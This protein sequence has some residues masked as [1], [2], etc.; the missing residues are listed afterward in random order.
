MPWKA[1]PPCPVLRLSMLQTRRLPLPL[2]CLPPRPAERTTSRSTAR[3]NRSPS[4]RQAARKRQPL[5][6]TSV[7]ARGPCP[8]KTPAPASAPVPVPAPTPSPTPDS[9]PEALPV[10][11]K[12]E[13]RSLSRT[14]TAPPNLQLQP[15]AQARKLIKRN[16]SAPK[17]RIASR[18]TKTARSM[19]LVG[20]PPPLP[21]SDPSSP[22]PLPRAMSVHIPSRTASPV[23]TGQGA[24]RSKK[25]RLNSLWSGL[26]R[27]RVSS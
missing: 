21:T 15:Q 11:K 26:F 25:P 27:L 8:D 18:H 4:K 6:P 16:P 14:S 9:A 23:A 13:P 7:P 10:A 3:P 24:D 22:P 2:P 17:P 20:A 12:T 19:S 1:E 5:A